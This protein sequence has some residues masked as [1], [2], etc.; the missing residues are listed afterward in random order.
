MI[1]ITLDITLKQYRG[2]GNPRRKYLPAKCKKN[3][4]NELIKPNG[5]VPGMGT[6]PFTSEE[7]CQELFKFKFQQII[8]VAI[9]QYSNRLILII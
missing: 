3:R 9:K 8:I 4:N 7:P 5:P 6:G 2:C 1:L